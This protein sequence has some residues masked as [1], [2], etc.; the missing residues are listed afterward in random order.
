MCAHPRGGARRRS[1]GF[2]ASRGLTGEIGAEAV[3]VASARPRGGARTTEPWIAHLKVLWGGPCTLL[4]CQGLCSGLQYGVLTENAGRPFP[5]LGWKL[6][7]LFILLKDRHLAICNLDNFLHILCF[8]SGQDLEK[9]TRRP[10]SCQSWSLT[11]LVAL[12]WPFWTLQQ[13]AGF[14][15]LLVFPS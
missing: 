15:A 3:G 7:G 2:K 13:K 6:V 4:L 1:A 12:N 8:P 10:L 9:E 5:T 14:P 11:H